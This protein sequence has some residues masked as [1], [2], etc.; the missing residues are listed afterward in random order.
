MA[1][2]RRSFLAGAGAAAGA[3]LLAPVTGIGSAFGAPVDP[4]T[5]TRRRLVVVFLRGGNDGLNTIVPR[6]DVRGAAR[7]SV[8]R[9]A[10]P[11]LALR[12]E[13]LLSLGGPG[14][15]GHLLGFNPQLAGLSSLYD[16]GRVAI[17]QGVGYANSSFSHFSST[18][19]W[20]SGEPTRSPTSG[21]LGRHLDRHPGGDGEL[22]GLAVGEWVPLML[23]GR[24]SDASAITSLA[25]GRF[26]DG[27]TLKARNRHE[28]LARFASYA[29]DDPLRREAAQA[30]GRTVELVDAIERTPSLPTDGGGVLRSL[31]TA[32]SMLEQP[33]GVETVL[34][35]VPGYDTHANQGPHHWDKLGYLDEGIAAFF[36]GRSGDRD[37]GVGPLPDALASRTLMLVVSEFGRRLGENGAPGVAGTDHGTAGPVIVIGPPAASTSAPRLV[38]GIHGEHPP[39]GTVASP[40]LNLAV[41]TDF[42]SV[43]RAVLEGWLGDEDS[44]FSATKPLALFRDA[45]PV[46]TGTSG[47]PGAARTTAPAAGAGLGSTST[48]ASGAI[49]MGAGAPA[50]ETARS[51]G[52]ARPRGLVP[53]LPAALLNVAV[54]VA[55]LRLRRAASGGGDP[56]GE[57]HSTGD[58]DRRYTLPIEP[59]TGADDEGC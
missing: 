19:V 48:T 16:A 36:T 2:T 5:A 30:A 11:S 15:G 9:H 25:A 34:V 43:Y 7:L 8:Y 38:A 23:R 44:S 47:S 37:F 10:R 24:S 17:I 21:W 42:R 14:D 20:H 57:T 50:R 12:P 27:T 26:V 33:L 13:Q 32:R 39:L 31:L 52:T 18:D 29:G 6:G 22:R 4:A 28:A 41:T 51:G 3:T 1:I 35:S 54:G 40:A 46:G 45:A 49:A 58:D 53:A 59:G 55:A 56:S